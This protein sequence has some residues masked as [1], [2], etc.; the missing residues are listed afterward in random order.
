MK[1]IAQK[2]NSYGITVLPVKADKMP[3]LPKSWH[4]GFPPSDFEHA[5]R[6]AIVCGLKSGNLECID[7]DNHQNDAKERFYDFMINSKHIFD[8]YPFVITKTAGGGYHVVY[9]CA[10]IAGNLKL[11]ST[12]MKDEKG[13]WKPDTVIETRGQG[14]YFV[15]APSAG[16]EILRGSYENVPTI[17]ENDRD[18]LFE[19]ARGYNTWHEEEKKPYEPKDRPGD[20]YNQSSEALEDVKSCLRGEGW[21]HV[22]GHFWRRPGKDKGYSATLGKIHGNCFYVFTDNAYPFEKDKVYS[23]FVV[24][25]MLQYNGDLSAFAKELASRN[26]QPIR[27]I[28]TPKE[29]PK[30]L[31]ERARID[32]NKNIERP[33]VVLEIK[34]VGLYDVK[35]IRLFTLGNFS[36]ITGKAKSKKTFLMGIFASSLI[37]NKHFYDK[38]VGHLP[39]N[40]QKIVY[41]DTEQ[42]DYDV[43]NT[44]KRISYLSDGMRNFEMYQLREFTPIERCS[45]IEERLQSMDVGFV[46]IDGIADL[47][48]AVNDEEESTRVVSLLLRWTKQFSCHIVNVIHQNKGNDFATGW[49]GS[50]I[51]KKAEIIISVTKDKAD[52]ARSIVSC[53]LSRGADFEDF[54]FMINSEGMPVLDTNRII[55]EPEYE[56]PF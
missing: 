52:N 34:E 4:D 29:Q 37:N 56:M 49:L 9:R 2:Y 40:K 48:N 27:Q 16:Y 50:S 6:I 39:E 30:S 10:E 32:L 26:P 15:A 7:F 18:D 51:M 46:V 43:Y 45:M 1:E 38:F 35:N 33:P 13:R 44:A 36:A 11:A 19:L 28:A 12:P 14:G 20:L 31:L 24:V 3:L 47:A 8:A 55:K 23:P 5:E 22:R 41:F 53:D 42:G 21:T 17:H 54:A 25:A